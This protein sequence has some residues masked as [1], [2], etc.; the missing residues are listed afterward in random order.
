MTEQLNCTELIDKVGKNWHFNG[1]KV[2]GNN[3]GGQIKLLRTNIR[4]KSN[5]MHPYNFFR[6]KKRDQKSIYSVKY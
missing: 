3:P 2:K 6:R 5:I 1:E 4:N